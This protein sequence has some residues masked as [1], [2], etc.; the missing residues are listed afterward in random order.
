MPEGNK[1]LSHNIREARLKMNITQQQAADMLGITQLHYGRLERGDRRVSLEQLEDI[2]QAFQVSPYA[3]IDG[4]FRA[5]VPLSKQTGLSPFLDRFN[6][7]LTHCTP[8][9]QTLCYDICERIVRGK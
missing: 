8:E 1:V 2:A 7:L 3:L 4:C 9:E 5:P 6:A